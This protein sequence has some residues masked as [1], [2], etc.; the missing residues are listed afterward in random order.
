LNIILYSHEVK[1]ALETGRVQVRRPIKPQPDH[2]CIMVGRTLRGGE[3][4]IPTYNTEYP[5][6]IIRCPFG[7]RGGKLWVRETW[8]SWDEWQSDENDDGVD[9]WFKQTYVAYRATPR[10]GFRPEDR[11]RIVFLYDS[12]PLEYNRNLL[13]PWRSPVSMPRLF[14]RL[15][16]ENAGVGV[17][18]EDSIWYWVG[19]FRV[20]GAR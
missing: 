14:S 13:G 7:Q 12:T 6:R 3:L 1:I 10:I 9:E 5:E 17:E 8:R 19:S 16:V 18:Q 4:H 2:W 20:D 15:T 11:Q